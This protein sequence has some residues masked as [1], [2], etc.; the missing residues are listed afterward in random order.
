VD[1]PKRSEL[2]DVTRT[3][4]KIADKGFV[5]ASKSKKLDAKMSLAA[6]LG[7]RHMI[8]THILKKCCRKDELY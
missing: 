2:Q 3:Y 4:E 8:N 1:A 7:I 5:E 6:I